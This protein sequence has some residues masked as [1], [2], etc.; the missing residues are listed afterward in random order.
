MAQRDYYEVLGV[1]RDADPETIKRA[2][3]KLALQY[4]PDRNKEPDADK[5]F[6]AVAEAYAVLSDPE[7]RSRYDRLG[8]AGVSGAAGQAGA[9]IHFDNLEDIFTRFADVFGGSGGLFENLFGFGGGRGGDGTRGAAA[10]GRSLRVPVE[11]DLVDVLHGVERSIQYA[12]HDRC[13]TCQG[14]GAAPGSGSVQA[15]PVC[16]GRGHVTQQQGF[17]AFR[18]ACPRCGGQGRIVQ[19]PCVTCHGSGTET[20]RREL[21]VRIPA[22]I[23][24]GAQIRL[25]GEGDAGQ[26]GG[27]HGDLFVEV[28]VREHPSFHREGRD[29]Y[30]EVS[31][32]Y[33]QA[34]LGDKLRVPTLEG[35][36]RLEIPAGTPTGKLFPLRG[37]GLPKLHGGRRGDLYAR[38]FVEVPP[39]L[40]REHKSLLRKLYEFE[41]EERR[42]TEGAR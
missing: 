36:T 41:Q 17:L 9:G 26:A 38:V 7:K 34:A 4:H 29:L 24:D 12:R 6:K 39:R 27:P 16:G 21:A 1:P 20:R 37:Q 32:R 14:S 13:G 19:K 42:R 35:E 25:P 33:T 3:R 28:H 5:K 18:S 23:E 10:R 8:H 30:T 15:C 31:M 22:G 11:I 2:F 40:S